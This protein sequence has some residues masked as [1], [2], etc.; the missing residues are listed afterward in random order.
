MEGFREEQEEAV[1]GGAMAKTHGSLQSS[2]DEHF[3]FCF[4]DVAL[5]QGS[6]RHGL[7][8]HDFE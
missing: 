3:D 7:N 5:C 6:G 4:T 2:R 8:W 1:E